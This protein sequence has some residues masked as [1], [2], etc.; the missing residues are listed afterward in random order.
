MLHIF[1]I[2]HKIAVE[3]RGYSGI[4]P[5]A[6]VAEFY[7]APSYKFSV[8][9]TDNPEETELYYLIHSG[10]GETFYFRLTSYEEG[11]EMAVALHYFFTGIWPETPVNTK[12]TAGK[13]LF[14]FLHAM[15]VPARVSAN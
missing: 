12:F 2:L 3:L 4:D 15:P 13:P 1:D 14:L 11:A 9:V 10:H 6:A 7:A 8:S 5:E